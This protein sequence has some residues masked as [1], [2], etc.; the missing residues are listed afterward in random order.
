[1]FQKTTYLSA[2]LATSI[3]LGVLLAAQGPASDF[4]PDSVFTGSAL[5]GWH[6]V[7]SAD[8]KAESGEIS[9]SVR[10]GGPGGWLV[11]DRSYQDLDFFT[12]FRCLGDCQTGVLFRLEK[13]ADGMTGVY[14]SLT[15]GDL[16]TYRLTL[17]AEGHETKRQP[18]RPVGAFVRTAPAPNPS[19]PAGGAR[20]A[21]VGGAG[22][23][24]PAMKLP[25]PLQPL[26]PPPPGLRQTDWNSLSVAVDADIIRPTLNQSID[27]AA[28]AT[29]DR[30]AGYGPVALH[31][32]AG[33]VHF[34]DV[35]F[36]DLNIRMIPPEKTSSRF[37]VQRLDDFYYAWGAAAADFNRDGV[38]DVVAGPYYYL[39]PDYTSRR[40]IYVTPAFSP[41]T[42]FASSMIDYAWD[43][44][45]DGWPDVLAGEGRPMSLYVNPKGEN[46][47]WAK[48]PVLP[49][50]NS[51]LAVMR[52]LDAD[53]QPEIIFG[54][55]TGTPTGTLAFAKPNPANPTAPWIVHT[56]SEPGLA[57]GHSMGAGDINGDGR[58]D[59]LQTAGW[60]E[61]PPPGSN[62]G[63]WIYHPEAF[64]RWGRSEGAGGAEIRV[65]DVNGDKLN[66]V[67]TSLNAHGFGLAWFEQKRDRA[68]QISFERHMV[69]DD[70]STKN[71]GDVTFSEMHGA[72]TA[73]VD[74]DGIPDF[75]TGKR[76]WSHLDSYTD[77]DPYGAPVLYWFRTVR[78]PKA[79]G[80]A[81]FVPELIHNRSGVGS[82]FSAV[83]LNKDGAIDI[84][85]STDRGTFIFWGQRRPG[86]GRH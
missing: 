28:G 14:V 55:G 68:G 85:T 72:T 25:V 2:T 82:Q 12:R 4:R 57:Y 7:G 53:G 1:M 36:K 47:R 32:G 83:D 21:A 58:V 42:Q 46:R 60:W 24:G 31:V 11:L 39:G 84:I 80:G 62:Q 43:F 3:G 69:M 35:A 16:A 77:A 27:I 30:S 20:G 44:T 41:S 56:I 73:D 65:F 63:L 5:S 61:Q 13:T 40:E 10:P 71:P 38:L 59:I 70:Y 9:A 17:D 66:D 86:A 26:L 79:P 15:K 33:E 45:G 81:E 6:I 51:E 50:I 75:I 18:L 34:K 29:D 74:G 37:R 23:G 64:G 8:W 78:N 22:T 49:Q 48:F 76:Y 54:T 52:D 67:M 19:A